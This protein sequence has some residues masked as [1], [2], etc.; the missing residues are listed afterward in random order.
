MNPQVGMMPDSGYAPSPHS[1][2]WE[3]FSTTC[4]S[5][6]CEWAGVTCDTN[7]GVGD[8]KLS[9]LLVDHKGRVRASPHPRAR[10]CVAALSCH[11]CY[12]A[13]AH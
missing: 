8:L 13:L 11:S 12:D 6:S 9:V 2:L 4:C 1:D 3:G 7:G 5:T 10:D